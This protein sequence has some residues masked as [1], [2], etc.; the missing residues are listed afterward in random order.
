MR[1]A[2]G[3]V[4]ANVWGKK[5]L[6]K[7]ASEL[8]AHYA[9]ET[10]G[11]QK[12]QEMLGRIRDTAL[13]LFD[14]GKG[15]LPDKQ[16]HMIRGAC[17][18]VLA[19]Y[20]IVKDQSHDQQQAFT[21][22]MAAFQQTY[23]GMGKFIMRPL[24]WVS[25]DPVKTLSSSERL[26]SWSQSM[27]GSSMGFDQ[28]VDADG[29]TLIVNRCAFHQFF[30]DHDEPLLTPLVCAWDRNWMDVVDS[31]NRP[32]R[33]ERPTTISTGADACRFRFVRDNDK[34]NP[35]KHDVILQ[36]RKS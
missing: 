31:A 28:A 8:D 30:I 20:R 19:A 22:V 17:S 23:Q 33:V 2:F 3:T 25:R 32:V 35:S 34:T 1:V 21:L 15:T 26:R 12:K 27:Y 16:A 11:R 9:N 6:R 4:A 24:L 18:L 5:F 14:E 36:N 13:Q 7:L 29:Y 10:R